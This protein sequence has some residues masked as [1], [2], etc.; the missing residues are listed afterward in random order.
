MGLQGKQFQVIQY[1]APH[2]HPRISQRTPISGKKQPI[3]RS[4]LS[5]SR[6]YALR[7]HVKFVASVQVVCFGRVGHSFW[8]TL[9]DVHH[10]C[11]DLWHLHGQPMNRSGIFRL[12]AIWNRF[13]APLLEHGNSPINV[14]ACAGSCLSRTPSRH[15]QFVQGLLAGI[16]VRSLFDWASLE[17]ACALMPPRRHVYVEVWFLAVGRENL[18]M[19]S[20]RLRLTPM[21][22]QDS[23]EHS[24]LSLWADHLQHRIA[25]SIFEVT[26]RPEGLRA[27]IAHFIVVQGDH[28][29]HRG[30]LLACDAWPVLAMGK[31]RAVLAYQHL[32]VRDIFRVA[33]FGHYCD[34][35]QRP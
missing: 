14:S 10:H 17:E 15:E 24:C 13:G 32:T 26:P 18:C 27:T 2:R 25:A 28:S 16:P 35:A 1:Y 21:I 34:N 12:I 19:R 23:F 30:V 9:A 29:R 22:S 11:R 31:H 7:Q 5:G 33:Q 3:K 6:G 8:T 20:R 4:C